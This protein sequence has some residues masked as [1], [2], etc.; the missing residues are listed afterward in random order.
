[1]DNIKYFDHAATTAVSKEVL[2]AMLPY[3]S[4]EYGN[5]SSMYSISRRARKA[6]EVARQKVAQAIN[7][8]PNEIYFTS[9]GSESDNLAIKGI[10]YAN[11]NKG[12]HIITSK[13]EHHAVLETCENLE[14]EGF[15]VTYLDVDDK[16]FVHLDELK[17]AIKPN[18]ILITIMFAN[19]EIGTIEPIKEIGKIARDNNIYFHTDCVQAIG[20]VKIDVQDMNI[21]S[22]SMSGHK[23]YGPK[24][25]GVLYVKDGIEFKKLQNGGHQENNK[26]AGTENVPGIVGMGKAIE[27]AYRDFEKNERHLKQLRDFFFSEIEK[28]VPN[29][30]INGDRQKRLPGNCN[31]SFA[32]VDA[33]ELLM[34]LDKKGI[35]ASAGSACSTGTTEISHVLKAIG[36]LDKTA[37][38]TLRLTFGKE[39]TIE[40]VEFLVKAIEEIVKLIR[41]K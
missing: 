22:L 23:L 27:I 3:F 5:A 28:R 4:T 33:E 12:N 18:T 14:E 16:G 1:M 39:N 26:R 38:G 10:A 24:G 32:K 21:D 15:E 29:I 35:C 34:K 9:G 41:N 2:E 7:A 20:N 6:I 19:N 8:K 30:K 25:I 13:I 17:K 37:L 31:V 40:D 11:K 36:L